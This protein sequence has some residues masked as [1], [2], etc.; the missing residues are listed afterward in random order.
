MMKLLY[1]VREDV[2]VEKI[3]GCEAKIYH[4]AVNG[5]SGLESDTRVVILDMGIIGFS[6]LEC[7]KM[8]RSNPFNHQIKI[9][10]CSRKYNIRLIKQAFSLG[11]D[12]FVRLPLEINEIKFILQD[13]KKNMKYLEYNDAFKFVNYQISSLQ[14]DK[15]EV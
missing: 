1:I 3:D 12:F 15:I 10:I 14:N 9:I 5:L 2:L 7:L 6:G 11:A 4:D 8:I 13:I